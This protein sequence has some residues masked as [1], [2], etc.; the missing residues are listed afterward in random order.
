MGKQGIARD[1]STDRRLIKGDKPWHAFPKASGLYT[2]THA[3][4]GRKYVGC[5]VDLRHR[6]WLHI[7]DFNKNRHHNPLMQRLWNRDGDGAFRFEIHSLHSDIA[8]LEGAEAKLIAE[9]DTFKTPHGMNLCKNAISA[10]GRKWNS[11][12]RAKM[13]KYTPERVAGW[14][15]ERNAGVT[16]REI[17][18]REG[19]IIQ[20][21]AKITRK[22][23][24]K[25]SKRRKI[26][27]AAKQEFRRLYSDGYSAKKIA[28]IF[29]ID[30]K[31]V[32]MAVSD[33]ITPE[34]R[35]SRRSFFY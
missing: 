32:Q 31:S 27:D 19:L 34:R 20:N 30:G 33:L 11:D 23:G 15:E 8:T 21:L 18:A 22:A 35:K 25:A 28:R 4:S 24:F 6:I 9:L 1:P 16:V 26:S 3:L 12:Q 7:W 14:I 17:A 13:T 10:I 29:G 5:G 2:I